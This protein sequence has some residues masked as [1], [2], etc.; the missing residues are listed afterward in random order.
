[1]AAGG[2]ARLGILYRGMSSTGV[3][4]PLGHVVHQGMSSTGACLS[5]GAC[6]PPGH[7]VH[8]GMSRGIMSLRACCLRG[9]LYTGAYCPPGHVV[10][11]GI[12]FQ[13]SEIVKMDKKNSGSRNR[14][15][16]MISG[17]R[18]RR[19]G[20]QI[21]YVTLSRLPALHTGCSKK[22]GD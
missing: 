9:I 4:R 5:T 21:L 2:S 1:M 12:Q 3:C 16:G 8:S 17:S 11:Q 14:R 18:N 6:Y 15:N 13:E 10:H 19:K 20:Q 7:I 22:R